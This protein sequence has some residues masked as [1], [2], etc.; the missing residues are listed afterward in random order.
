MTYLSVALA[1]VSVACVGTLVYLLLQKTDGSLGN[2]VS[3]LSGGT[4]ASQQQAVD[5][6]SERQ[7]AM[8]VADQ[9]VLR[10]NTFG[11]HDLDAQN[12]LPA[13]AARVHEVTSA[14]FGADFDTNL[15][16]PEQL[17]AGSGY[18]RSAKL[19]ST[20]VSSIDSDSASVLVAGV[21]NSSYPDPQHPKDTSKRIQQDPLPFRF[22]VSLVKLEG[23]WKVDD[24]SPVTGEDSSAPGGTNTSPPDV[25][26][27]PPTS[28]PSGGATRKPSASP[29]GGAGR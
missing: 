4:T 8:A 26:V 17:V 7:A 20:G 18:N 19:F 29:S 11:P 28:R 6:S 2:R 3:A 15:K 25:Q 27:S 24:F 9:F 14:K 5:L 13:Y 16:L 21:I 22:K 23:T 1:I 12:H 10:V